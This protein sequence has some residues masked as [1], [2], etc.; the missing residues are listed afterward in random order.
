MSL[1]IYLKDPTSEELISINKEL[2]RSKLPPYNYD[3]SLVPKDIKFP[4][5]NWGFTDRYHYNNLKIISAKLWQNPNWI[6]DRDFVHPQYR[7]DSEIE[8]EKYLLEEVRIQDK[9]HLA[10]PS[11]YG[12]DYIP[13]DFGSIDLPLWSITY[14]G[15]SVNLCRELEFIASSLQ[16]D[17]DRHHPYFAWAK[18]WDK[19]WEQEIDIMYDEDILM[20]EKRILCQLY[21]I[22]SLSIK[23]NLIVVFN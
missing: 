10:C 21:N 12:T 2:S 15:S 20:G 11:F 13:V 3:E 7:K 18:E 16:F 22:A 8:L 5:F 4:D 23:Y 1:I 14:Y 19:E 9:S 6:T 17:L